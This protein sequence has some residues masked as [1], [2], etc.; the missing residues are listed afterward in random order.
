MNYTLK[1][2]L[3]IPRLR[4]LLDS[5]DELHSMPSAIIDTEGNVLIA[6]AWQDICT[7]F[8]RVNSDT[9]KMCIESDRHIEARLGE[10]D[11]HVIYRCPMGLVD[12]A[13]PIVLEGK[14]LGN[15]FTGQLFMEAPDEAFFINQARKYGF[16]EN[17]YLEAMR[18]VPFFAEDKLH[19]NLNFIHGLAHMLSEQGLQNKRL[20]E[21]WERH[22]IILQTAM[23]GFWLADMQ[24]RL[25]EVNDAYCRMSGYSKQE[26]LS[27]SITD[28]E[29]VETQEGTFARIKK[30]KEKG[31]DRFESRHC[32]KDGSTFDVEVSTQYQPYDGGQCVT[33]L[34]DISERKQAEERLIRSEHSFRSIIEESPVPLA[35]ND[36]QGNITF[37]NRAFVQTV[38][39]TLDDIST[40]AEWWPR[41]YPDPHYRQMLIDKWQANMVVAQQTGNPMPALEVDVTCKDGL[42]RT[43]LCSTSA[44]REAFSGT[45]LV[46]LYDITE[47]KRAEMLLQQSEGGF[48]RLSNEQQIILNA[49]SVGIALVKNR[50]IV[51]ANPTHCMIFGYGAGTT[52]N[53]D[54]SE[55]YADQES[56]E[57]VG[58]RAHSIM[59]SGGIFE[60][61]V[62]MKKRDGTPIW[63]SLVGQAV[64]NEN[65]DEG[66]IWI[67]QDVTERKR[68][69]EQRA[70]L[71]VQL[72]SQT[73]LQQRIIDLLPDATF[74][75][76][77]EHRVIAWNKAMAE[78]TGISEAEMLGE[79]DYAYAIPFYGE[80]R[81]MLIDMIGVETE[82]VLKLY[83]N[84]KVKGNTLIAE[85]N[86]QLKGNSDTRHHWF[87]A[88][89]LLDQEGH[90]IGA[91]ESVRDV[92]EF[93][94]AEEERELL[95]DQLLQSQKME[96]VGQLAGGV[97]HDF[98]NMLGVI[99]GYA[100]LALMKLD[101]SQPYY[102]NFKEISSAASRSSD[103]TRQLLAFARKQEIAPKVIDLNT[104]VSGMLN[105][106]QRLIGEN[107]NINWHPASSLW[108]VKMDPSQIDQM[109]ANLC[110]NAR[111]AISDVGRIIIETG[112]SSFDSNY[113]TSHTYV[114]P[115]EYVA[116]V[117]S[118]DGCGM[119]KETLAH[120]F[121]PF[122]TT[123]GVGEGTGLGLATVYGIIKQNNGF[124]NVYSEPGQ[125]TTFTIY[126]PRHIGEAGEALNESV[127][128]AV[129]RGSEFI[130]LVE[131][132]P[133]IL[134]MTAL[135]L[136][137]LG[138]TVL[139][140]ES[141]A[142]AIRLFIEHT[143]KIQMLMTDV[144]MPDMNGRDL[145]KELHS[146]NPQLKCLFMS[147]YTANIIA[148]QGVLDEG[149]NFIQK[150]FSLLDLA[151]KVREVLDGS[152]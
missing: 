123:K 51:W 148:L 19:K 117:V 29:A 44:M 47:R 138:Y 33:F 17:E 9:E 133:S 39:Y 103:L 139:K 68:A 31:E 25:I 11:P 1:E 113:C 22:R 134:Q 118:D 128:T 122:F 101:P 124:V 78:M 102:K 37:V 74:A 114:E 112:N 6:T 71:E 34:K 43:F 4:E 42:I 108:Q 48:R 32:R 20:Q 27:M 93:R 137:G 10:R 79:G 7:R 57:M 147:G 106:L 55:F 23:S 96:A 18:K 89:P 84:V 26:L 105:M 130:L 136:E 119:D 24:G 73:M 70:E 85:R 53:V 62:M 75:I 49:S 150:P 86:I 140:A 126:L 35:I 13:M 61:E 2:L 141:V 50:K 58:D 88:A 76:D 21:N 87:S 83:S 149:V 56:Y 81:P 82:T 104:T 65:M 40:L 15:V 120:I 90:L 92:T 146:L 72:I 14:H 64:N 45:H 125:G 67:V 52:C 116:L 145:V 5:L 109:L 91:I 60:E 94:R 59:A 144:I 111:H 98:N 131:D 66:S 135:L 41:A 143:D 110:V 107:V 30:I 80:R 38:G 12:A 132:E 16:D 151:K 3:D 36:D 8:H 115:G 100:E 99:I 54:T 127:K 142:E 77:S 95:R 152:I 46:F 97:A 63:C 129:P 69:E 121:E 28:L